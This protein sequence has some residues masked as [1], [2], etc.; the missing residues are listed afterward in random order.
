MDISRGAVSHFKMGCLA[1]YAQIASF[2]F[3]LFVQLANGALLLAVVVSLIG[4][5]ASWTIGKFADLYE[6]HRGLASGIKKRTP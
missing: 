3:L 5:L 6:K 2:W 1:A 4:K